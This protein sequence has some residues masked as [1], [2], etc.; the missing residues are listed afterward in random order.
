[1]KHRALAW[2]L[3][4]LGFVLTRWQFCGDAI[5]NID[6][7]EYA[8][9]ADALGHGW[10]PGVD[11]LGTT[12]PPGIALLYSLL[13]H[14]FGHSLAVVHV[15]HVVI[16]LLSGA[17][18]VELGI[19]LWGLGAA[20]P[21]AL[22][23]WMAASTWNLP[24]EMLAL[25]VESPGVLFTTLALLLAWLRPHS[26]KALLMAGAA[27]GMATIF[28]QS[29]LFFLLPLGAAVQLTGERRLARIGVLLAGVALPWLPILAVYAARGGLGWALDSW[30]RY[31]MTYAGDTGALGFLQSP[32]SEF[33]RIRV[34]LDDAAGP[35]DWR[36]GDARA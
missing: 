36:S 15:A 1:M 9:A 18:L 12:K 24:Q 29:F 23:Y 3:L 22:L 11:L 25:N 19:A 31:P 14:I 8:V 30:V 35:G 26:T 28:R 10:L 16:M 17:L 33:H 34:A 13:F 7:A 2:L 20:A 6:E 27:A 5:Y 32:V 4:I 21:T